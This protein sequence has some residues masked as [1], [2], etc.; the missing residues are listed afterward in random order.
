MSSWS[1]HQ[2]PGL[3]DI[4]ATGVKE[5][6]KLSLQ[7]GPRPWPYAGPYSFSCLCTHMMRPASP[8]GRTREMRFAIGAGCRVWRAAGRKRQGSL[9]TRRRCPGSRFY[10]LFIISVHTLGN[11]WHHSCSPSTSKQG[12]GLDDRAGSGNTKVLTTRGR[13]LFTGSHL[14]AGAFQLLLPQE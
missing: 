3:K 14:L 2:T 9:M 10:F 4:H 8:S 13:C 12:D 6:K 11:R 1:P 7:P 5:R